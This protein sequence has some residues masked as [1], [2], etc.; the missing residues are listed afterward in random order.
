MI[1]AFIFVQSAFPATL[2]SA[3]SDP[4]ALWLTTWL[5]LDLDAATFLIRK[6]GH[7][8]EYAVLG[9]SLMLTVNSWWPRRA[10]TGK[11]EQAQRF[12][13]K[14]L[15]AACIIGSLYAVTDEVHQLFVEGR[16]CEFRDMCID[17]AGVALGAVIIFIWILQKLK[18]WQNS[19][20]GNTFE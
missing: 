8:T 14:Q 13:G 2:S 12:A 16:S 19:N 10:G 17:A 5:P 3:E 15:A 9:A 18:K 6:L 1:M 7:F 4:I 11:A 20:C